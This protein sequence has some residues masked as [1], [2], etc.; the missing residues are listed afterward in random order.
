M[1]N[2]NNKETFIFS[3]L[4]LKIS[5]ILQVTLKARLYL[6]VSFALISRGGGEGRRGEKGKRTGE[7]EKRKKRRETKR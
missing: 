4:C 5:I 2:K 6:P 7:K 1:V 3:W